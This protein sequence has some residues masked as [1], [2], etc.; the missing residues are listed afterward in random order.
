MISAL[1]LTFAIGATPAPERTLT[2]ITPPGG[3]PNPAIG[4]YKFT[5]GPQRDIETSGGGTLVNQSSRT[6]GNQLILRFWRSA[7]GYPPAAAVASADERTHEV[8]ALSGSVR[9]VGAV[10]CIFS[11]PNPTPADL[12]D[13]PST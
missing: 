9:K 12:R 10:W 8:R 4:F 13:E 7:Q 5:P 2:P 11:D 1:L 6:I 3:C